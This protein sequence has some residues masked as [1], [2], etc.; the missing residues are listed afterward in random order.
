MCRWFFVLFLA[1]AAK[2]CLGGWLPIDTITS[3]Q[4]RSDMTCYNNARAVASDSAGNIHV[5]W[6]GETLG[7]YQVWF[8]RWHAPTRQWSED[9]VI[10]SDASGVG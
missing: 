9:T 10:S 6:R 4:N 7:V 8:S 3:R 1:W 2:V 5:V